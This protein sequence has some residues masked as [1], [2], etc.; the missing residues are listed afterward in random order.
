MD[1]AITSVLIFPFCP[2]AP[3][4]PYS[5]RQSL[6]H[7]SYPLVMCISSLATPFPILYFT[8]PWLFCNYISVLL[9]PLPSSLIL[10]LSPPLWQ[11]SS[12]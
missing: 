2:P 3:S 9:N 6:C 8:S 7:C 5:L 11:S 12:N 4:T 10:P 1:Y